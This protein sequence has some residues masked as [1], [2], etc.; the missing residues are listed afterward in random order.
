MCLCRIIWS[1]GVLAAMGSIT[2]PSISAFVS[3]HA[4]DDQ[5]G[6]GLMSSFSYAWRNCPLGDSLKSVVVQLVKSKLASIGVMQFRV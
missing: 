4:S 6:N 3:A 2:Y 5:Q 1:A